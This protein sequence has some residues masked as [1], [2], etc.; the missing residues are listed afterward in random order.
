VCRVTRGDHIEHL[1]LK[2]KTFS[3]FP[4]LWKIPLR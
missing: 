2:K 3:G 1:L 4:W